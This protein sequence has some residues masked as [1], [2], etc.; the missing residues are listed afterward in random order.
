MNYARS[1]KLLSCLVYIDQLLSHHFITDG[2]KFSCLIYIFFLIQANMYQNACYRAQT[3]DTN[4]IKRDEMSTD[5]NQN[6]KYIY[7][8]LISCVAW[9]H[10]F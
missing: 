3:V 8:P 5:I 7:L 6:N 4:F 9:K 1:E 2:V 10:M